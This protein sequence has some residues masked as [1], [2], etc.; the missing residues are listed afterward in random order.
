MSNIIADPHLLIYGDSYGR[1]GGNKLGNTEVTSEIDTHKMNSSNFDDATE[2][3]NFERSVRD[4]ILARLGHPVVRVELSAF[5]LK[6][7]IEEAISRFS[8]HAPFWN[9]Q[10]ATFQASAGINMYRLPSHIAD[11]LSYVVYKKTLIGT[12][13]AAGTLESDMFINYFT[14]NY[15]FP[16]F[17]VGEFYLMQQ[18]MEMIR[19]ILSNEGTHDIVNGNILQLYPTPG[20]GEE[21]IIEYR[22]VDSDTIHPAYR[23]WIQNYATAISKGMLGE[24]RGK[25]KTIPGP[26]GGAALNG[27]KLIERS[28]REKAKLEEDLRLQIEEP[29]CFTLF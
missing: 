15:S 3:N 2:F 18:H 6:S 9:R 4:F 17:G 12:N 10:F 8:Y 24:V 7:A 23:N 26:G 13:F 28:E 5:Q 1:Y 22:A 25:Y 14:N 27:D 11:N 20:F 29:P 19:K 21:V 16:A